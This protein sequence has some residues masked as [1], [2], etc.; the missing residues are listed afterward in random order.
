[1]TEKEVYLASIAEKQAKGLK[2][3]K[4]FTA[5]TFDVSEEAA[6]GELNRLHSSSDLPDEEVLGKYCPSIAKPSAAKP[7][8]R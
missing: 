3:V 6:Y 2:D 4:F 5:N 1:M 7:A 8:V